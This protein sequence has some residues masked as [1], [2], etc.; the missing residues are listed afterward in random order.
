MA[1]QSAIVA[2]TVTANTPA[3]LSNNYVYAFSVK[4]SGIVSGI[5]TDVRVF[6]NSSTSSFT[7]FNQLGNVLPATST[8]SGYVSNYYVL[9]GQSVTNGTTNGLL[10]IFTGETS[11][12]GKYLGFYQNFSFTNGM[13]Y[14]L[15]GAPAVGSGSPTSSTVLG[16]N[17]GGYGAFGIQAL[18]TPIKQWD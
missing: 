17:I 10:S 9:K 13:R 2:N 3:I 12:S 7:G 1:D 6:T 4:W 15:Y 18:T 8:G 5:G 11:G 16:G 14:N